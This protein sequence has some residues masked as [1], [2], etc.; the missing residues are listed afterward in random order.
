MTDV[1][2][3]VC[4]GASAILYREAK[5]LWFHSPGV[6][7]YFECTSCQHVWRPIEVGENLVDYYKTYY[8]HTGARKEKGWNC[9][10]KDLY[11]NFL[12]ED[13]FPRTLRGLFLLALMSLRPTAR[14]NV[15]NGIV[16]LRQAGVRAGESLLDYGCGDGRFINKWERYGLQV[17]GYDFDS[18]VLANLAARGLRIVD[19][20]SSV[21]FE[22]VFDVV[23][24]NHSLEHFAEPEK[25]LS[26]IKKVLKHNGKLICV[27][28]NSASWNHKLFSVH[29]RGLE[30]PRHINIFSETSLRTILENT[31]FSSPLSL[32]NGRGFES[33][34]WSSIVS[35]H[36]SLGSGSRVIPLRIMAAPILHLTARLAKSLGCG[37][38]LVL[39]VTNE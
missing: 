5:D 32:S 31:G 33:V 12:V 2:C 28:P 26:V 17:S 16:E 11:L 19:D 13:A 4:E 14:S 8:T 15:E 7:T 30:A 25:E 37:E 10:S 18:E 35:K 24:L 38:E 3:P 34:F 21:E 6:W 22:N 27:T 23:Y 9:Q 36:Q 39:V 29:W 20:P 1:S